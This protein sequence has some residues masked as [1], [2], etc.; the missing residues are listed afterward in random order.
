MDKDFDASLGA[1]LDATANRYV[2]QETLKESPYETTQVVYRHGRTEGELIGPFVR[3]RFVGDPHRGQAYD[4]LWRAQAMG[5]R[6]DHLP[7]VYECERSGDV[8]D[9]IMEYLHGKTLYEVA[10]QEGAGLDLSA[11]MV[12]QLCDAVSQ[13]HESFDQP[14]IHRDIKPSNVMVCNGRVVLIDLGIAR[15]YTSGASHDTTHYG[16]P[17]YAPPEQFGYKQTS[18]CSDV[19]ALGMTIAFCLMGQDPTL[20]L[21]EREFDD[22]RIPPAL[23]EVL[24]RAT[25]FDPAHR[26][27]SAR[28]LRLDFERAFEQATDEGRRVRVPSTETSSIAVP[29]TV[30]LPQPITEELDARTGS[31]PSQASLFHRVL[32]SRALDILGRIWNIALVSFSTLMLVFVGL[33]AALPTEQNAK[34]PPWFSFTAYVNVIAIPLIMV[35][36]LLLDKRRLRKRPPFCRFTW[37]K[38]LVAC[39]AICAIS[40]IVF[41]IVCGVATGFKPFDW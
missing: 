13:M 7:M 10:Q 30:P 15:T 14:L 37:P 34:Y 23:R 19:Y 9:V 25:Q 4:Q 24:V 21:R 27:Q 2:V 29:Q 3:K 31:E 28:E 11:R 38:E 33:S 1:W 8:V 41:F 17:G 20:E 5:K 40:I 35:T 22:P 26:H 6:F 18:T 39:V 32:N 36:Y 12:P 16:T